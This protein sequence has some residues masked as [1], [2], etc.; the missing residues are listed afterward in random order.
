MRS[1]G[2]DKGRNGNIR[3]CVHPYTNGT[4][5]K[6]EEGTAL[7]AIHISSSS[8]CT[9]LCSTVPS[10][11]ILPAQS[12][13][14]Y[15]VRACSQSADPSTTP[16]QSITTLG[17]AGVGAEIRH[18]F[19]DNIPTSTA[20]KDHTNGDGDD[21]SN[22]SSYNKA[23]RVDG[24]T[25][26]DSSRSR[27]GG[28]ASSSISTCLGPGSY[29][30]SAVSGEDD[31]S[32]S[33]M[34]PGPSR[35][36]RVGGVTAGRFGRGGSGNDLGQGNVLESLGQTLSEESSSSTSATLSLQ[37]PFSE[38]EAAWMGGLEHTFPLGT[39]GSAVVGGGSGVVDV[40]GGGEDS[41]NAPSLTGLG[42]QSGVLLEGLPA[43]AMRVR[44]LELNKELTHLDQCRR[45]LERQLT[46]ERAR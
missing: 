43:E 10:F 45:S 8:S 26:S 42:Q 4:I 17:G 12:R 38:D 7:T 16:G 30:S 2:V 21:N 5:M 27:S 6:Q 22:D 34:R 46:Q 44:M 23:R 35:V 41:S 14:S 25:F 1:D 19:H 31:D 40:Y 28:S 11:T 36:G 37:L 20:Y 9:R 29:T 15:P 3:A 18:P 13:T 24:D 33:W 39:V 32:D